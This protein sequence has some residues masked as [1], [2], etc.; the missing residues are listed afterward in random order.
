MA[1]GNQRA[2]NFP[3]KA[4][5]SALRPGEIV[6]DFFAGSGGASE[7]L[8]QALGRDPDV[9][10]NHDADALGMH[11]ANHPL[12]RH[13]EADVIVVHEV[14]RRFVLRLG[15]EVVGLWND[16]FDVDG[17]PPADG[18]TVTGVKRVLRSDGHE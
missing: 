4:L 8:R 10:V 7:A 15:D 17:V 1:D 3:R 5:V 14:A 16:A 13:M 18:T 6:V 2:F 11:A 12:T 9:A